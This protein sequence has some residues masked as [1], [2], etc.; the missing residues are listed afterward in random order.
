[1]SSFILDASAVLA[2]LNRE[3][4]A[5][6]V[7]DALEDG[8]V[9]GSINLAEVVSHLANLGFSQEEIA[10]S[11]G[12][13]DLEVESFIQEDAYRAGLMYPTTRQS[14]LSLA[15]RACLALAMRRE[16][17]VLT[18]DRAW[19]TLDLGIQVQLIR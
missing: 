12:A 9:L 1:M 8:G 13:L 15:D 10:D 2:V 7:L 16:L 5:E 4:G 17:P 11:L 18:S 19:S 14:G 6:Y 3:P